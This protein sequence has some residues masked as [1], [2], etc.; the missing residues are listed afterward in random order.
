MKANAFFFVVVMLLSLRLSAQIQKDTADIEEVVITGQYSQQSVKK[1]LYKV[2]IITRDDINRMSVNNVAEVLSQT[3]NILIIPEKNSGDSKASILG[4]GADYT[5]ILV[6]NIPV[7]GD[8][9]L[10]SN[11]DLTKISLANIERIEIVK[12]SMGVEF[13]NNAVA[14]VINYY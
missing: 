14:G 4:M 3:L 2:E 1:S 9:G 8:T 5:K 7:I 12:G 11:V 13:G 10:G 6:D